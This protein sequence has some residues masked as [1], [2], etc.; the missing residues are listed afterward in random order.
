M[1]DVKL[2]FD[3]VLWCDELRAQQKSTQREISILNL[4]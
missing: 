3:Q 1:Q 2:V 4:T